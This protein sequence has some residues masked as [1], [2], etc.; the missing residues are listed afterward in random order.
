[1]TSHLLSRL[2]GVAPRA[3]VSRLR[4]SDVYSPVRFVLSRVSFFLSFR[5]CIVRFSSLFVFLFLVRLWRSR[6]V[7]THPLSRDPSSAD[8]PPPAFHQ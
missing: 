6:V 8:P 3:R 4:F 5:F 2:F 7:A 1:M